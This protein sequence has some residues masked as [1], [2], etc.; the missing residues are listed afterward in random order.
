MYNVRVIPRRVL[1][2]RHPIAAICLILA[3]L[4]GCRADKDP[5][6]EEEETYPEEEVDQDGDGFL[7]EE[8]CNDN[9]S[10]I[11][12]GASEICDGIDN[13]CDDEVDEEVLS[14]FYADAD[15]DGF[16]NAEDTMQACEGGEGW[17]SSGNDCDD[18]DGESYPGAA[19]RCDGIDNDC[20][21]VVDEDVLSTWYTDADGD[22][23][24]DADS[25]LED[26]DPPDG[27]VSD[28]TDCDD[29][30]S[31]SY[32]GAE[33][34]CDYL[35]NDCDG[36]IDEDV[37]TTFYEDSDGDGYGLADSTT[38]DCSEPVGYASVADDCDDD[39]IDVNPD[40]TEL[41]DEIDNDCD[42]EVDEEEAADAVTWYL[43]A[44]GDGFGDSTA[45]WS[46]CEAPSGYLADDSDCDD[47]DSSINSSAD[48]YCDEVD[49]DCDGI[50]DND[51]AIDAS[52]WYADRDGDGYGDPDST[53]TACEQP[54]EY[55][56]DD[57][58]CAD[59]DADAWPGSTATETPDDG[60]DT[61]CDGNDFCTDLSC[62]GIPDMAIGT[63]YSGSSYTAD[64]L[65]Y[66][67]SG[68]DFSDSDVDA[69]EGTGS[70]SILVDDLDGDGYQDVVLP[71]YYSGSS[72]TADSYV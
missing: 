65:L 49:N 64:S 37:T 54:S 33:E 2:S 16:G 6:E 4:I 55:L 11:F 7:A 5:F 61:D 13:D 31:S 44:D 9:D 25:V 8:D 43:D 45:T 14:T 40:A 58:D 67:G 60:I 62:D 63:Y 10:A 72:Y 15:G 39:E 36:D 22:G 38:E 1:M 30:T 21:E 71:T 35:D 29:S 23:F 68:S 50:V 46:A 28:A 3:L 27:Y 41:C 42:G 59:S 32:P 48:E 53:T 70:W 12:P 24:G 20:D 57:S 56:E 47:T 34:I 26:C 66:Y 52:T 18:D 51:Y 17:V 19:E 69:I